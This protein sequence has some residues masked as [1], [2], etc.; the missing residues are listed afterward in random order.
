MV[1]SSDVGETG[2]VP[3]ELLRK[4]DTQDPVH[5]EI[6]VEILASQKITRQV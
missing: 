2:T 1:A 4:R 5:L 3:A 6:L